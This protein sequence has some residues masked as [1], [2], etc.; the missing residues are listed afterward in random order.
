MR[1]LAAIITGLVLLLP[2][3]SYATTCV[4][5]RPPKPIHP[6]CGFVIDPTGEPIANA[7][8]TILKD[9]HEIASMESSTDGR[10]A[11]NQLEAG[12]YDIRVQAN[13]FLPAFSS[14]T[15]VKPG[16][17]CK[18]ELGVLLAVGGG[19]SG[20]SLGKLNKPK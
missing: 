16:A 4:A 3:E 12:S 17:K 2:S 8:V 19:C 14:I 9:H 7:T 20:I 10:F 11:V 18:K 1:K 5:L 15:L 13:F 6:V